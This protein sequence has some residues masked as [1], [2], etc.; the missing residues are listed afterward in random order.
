M[1]NKALHFRE[2]E[3]AKVE[4]IIDGFKEHLKKDGQWEAGA[5]F[6]FAEH[7]RWARKQLR[8]HAGQ[9]YLTSNEI[10]CL[11]LEWARHC[12]DVRFYAVQPFAQWGRR[13]I[14]EG[15][16]PHMTL[17]QAIRIIDGAKISF[18]EFAKAQ[19]DASVASTEVEHV[20]QVP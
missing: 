13:C 15:R 20:G 8:R 18:V 16:T 7:Q 6:P 2:G 12:G 11:L 19:L 9:D 1:T 14:D 3:R 5:G 17:Q 10:A 4:A